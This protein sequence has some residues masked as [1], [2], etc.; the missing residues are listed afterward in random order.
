MLDPSAGI[1]TGSPLAEETSNFTIQVTDSGPPIQ[2]ASKEMT[3]TVKSDL[4]RNDDPATATPI[5]NGTFRASISPFADPAAGPANPDH[6]FYELTARPGSVV[7][8]ETMASRLSPE[9]PLDTVLEIVDSDGNR[10]STCQVVSGSFDKPCMNDDIQ[11]VVIQ[12][13]RLKFEVPE[14]GTESVTFYVHVLSWDGD[15]RP[16][17][18]YDLIVSGAN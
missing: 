15:A 7:T 16:D 11:D 3:L 2:S 13:S 6:D 5:S 10:F 17:Y 1:I 4:G 9:S 12:D 14:T 18:I 8:I